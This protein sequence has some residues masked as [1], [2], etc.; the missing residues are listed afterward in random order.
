MTR[1][2]RKLEL[3]LAATAGLILSISGGAVVE[4]AYSFR[5]LAG[6]SA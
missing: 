1:M 5:P 6:Q 2:P 3:V 4:P